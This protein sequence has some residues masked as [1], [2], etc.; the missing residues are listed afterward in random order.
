MI[1][2]HFK[3]TIF[4]FILLL[5]FI[6]TAYSHADHTPP[7]GDFGTPDNKEINRVEIA[8][9]LYGD[10]YMFFRGEKYHYDKYTEILVNLIRDRIKLENCLIV[11]NAEKKV[12]IRIVSMKMTVNQF[13]NRSRIYA[14]VSFGN[15]KSQILGSTERASSARIVIDNN[16][17]GPLDKAVMSLADKI[18]SNEELLAYIST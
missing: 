2:T 8:G 15:G 5:T 17:A 9:I 11:E 16:P 12:N 3:Q 7:S 4:C 1:R 6:H 14:E 18:A 13:T 10:K